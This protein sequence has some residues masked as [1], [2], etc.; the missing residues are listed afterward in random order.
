MRDRGTDRQIKKKKKFYC[1][2]NKVS[3]FLTENVEQK[4]EDNYEK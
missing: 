4:M 3:T 1:N 2:K